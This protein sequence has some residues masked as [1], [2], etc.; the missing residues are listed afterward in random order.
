[1]SK[2]YF[3]DGAMNAGKSAALLS[4]AHNYEEKE[5]KIIN[6]KRSEDKK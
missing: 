1:M 2:L 3:R 6:D 5:M 4:V